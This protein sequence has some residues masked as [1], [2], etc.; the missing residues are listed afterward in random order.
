LISKINAKLKE[1]NPS[2]SATPILQFKFMKQ[3][4]SND[5]HERFLLRPQQSINTPRIMLGRLGSQDS[6]VLSPQVSLMDTPNHEDDVNWHYNL[7]DQE[8]EV[9]KIIIDA[10]IQKSDWKEH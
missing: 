5:S 7:I 3:S 9:E 1:L 2:M 6:E 8:V 4:S 10:F